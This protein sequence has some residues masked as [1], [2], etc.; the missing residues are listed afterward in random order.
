MGGGKRG[1]GNP[2]TPRSARLPV[3]GEARCHHVCSHTGCGDA[4]AFQLRDSR[5]RIVPR[6][7]RAKPQERGW[8]REK[9]CSS[10][11]GQ[12]PSK[13]TGEGKKQLLYRLLSH[14]SPPRSP[15]AALKHVFP[16]GWGWLQR[17]GGSQRLRRCRCYL[18]PF[19]ASSSDGC[20]RHKNAA[21]T[22]GV[23]VP[24]G[25][26]VSLSHSMA[27]WTEIRKRWHQT[28]LPARSTAPCQAPR[29][30]VYRE[31]PGVNV[32]VKP[33]W[34]LD[35]YPPASMSSPSVPKPLHQSQGSATAQALKDLAVAGAKPFPS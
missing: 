4:A 10:A 20:K 7:P 34:F 5:P 16:Q 22:P 14:S 33:E 21:C 30:T 23:R 26:D 19:P 35:L 17:R 28:L 32:S 1:R 31:V 3:P 24:L 9:G 12:N 6:L 29:A 25:A 2:I 27:N 15:R 18:L 8:R 13:R 11:P